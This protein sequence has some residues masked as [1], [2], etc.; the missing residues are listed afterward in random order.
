MLEI[1][2]ASMDKGKFMDA[3]FTTKYGNFKNQ[4][5]GNL[6]ESGKIDIQAVLETIIDYCVSKDKK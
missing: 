6:K 4:L 3:A 2:Q 1:C 5:L